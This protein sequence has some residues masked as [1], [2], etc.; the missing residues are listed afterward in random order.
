MTSETLLQNLFE[1]IGFVHTVLE[2]TADVRAVLDR[3][4]GHLALTEPAQR[5]LE[6]HL[7]FTDI[8][9]AALV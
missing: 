6:Y 5:R 4:A 9:L 3:T 8:L 1:G 7:C 2:K